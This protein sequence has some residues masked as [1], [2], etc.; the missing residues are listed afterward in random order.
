MITTIANIPENLH[1]SAQAY[2]D[3]HPDWD[4]DRLYQ[5]AI[6]LFLMQNSSDRNAARTYLDTLFA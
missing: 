1:Q 5:A 6:S 3:G 4:T 2:L